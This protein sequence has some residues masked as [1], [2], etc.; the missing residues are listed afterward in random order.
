VELR[1]TFGEFRQE[2]RAGFTRIDA[3]FS[4]ADTAAA[5]RH[6]DFLKWTVGFWLV[7]LATLIGSIAA[8]ARILA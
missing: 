3:K 4:A 8:F 5:Q 6:A 1:R 7:S 2:M